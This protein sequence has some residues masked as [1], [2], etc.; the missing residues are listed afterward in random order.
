MAEKVFFE[1]EFKMIDDPRSLP[2]YR[3]ITAAGGVVVNE[4]QQVLMIFRRGKWD[5]PKGKLED[6]ES[7]ELCAE[8]EVM[9]ETG[10]GKIERERFLITTYHTYEEKRK[11]ILKET[12]WYLFRSPG[13]QQT[14]PQTEEDIL[15][16]R[17]VSLSGIEPFLAKSYELIRDVIGAAFPA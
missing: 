3:N 9:E 7:P 8:R 15:E 16:A 13:H 4:D 11:N 10:L 6:G 14:T 1:D 5:L 2:G 12:H 17:W